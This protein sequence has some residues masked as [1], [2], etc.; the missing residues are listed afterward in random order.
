MTHKRYNNSGKDV[1]P[2]FSPIRQ[3]H[4]ALPLNPNRLLSDAPTKKF[5]NMFGLYLCLYQIS[6]GHSKYPNSFFSRFSA[7]TAVFKF[8]GAL[9]QPSLLFS[10][11]YTPFLGIDNIVT[12]FGAIFQCLYC[13]LF[14]DI[15]I[16]F[17][18]QCI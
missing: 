16:A 11:F 10:A 9:E 1:N 15:I 3:I 7:G 5:I 17:L 12:W 8:Y 4:P 18:L 2:I 14:S 6:M 13:N